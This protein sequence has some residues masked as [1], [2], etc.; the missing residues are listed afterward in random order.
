MRERT[1]A[2]GGTIEIL[3]DQGFTLSGNLFGGRE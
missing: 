2:F 1:E 3:A